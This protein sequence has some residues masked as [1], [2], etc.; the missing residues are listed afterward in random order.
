MYLCMQAEEEAR[1]KAA[2]ETEAKRKA[3]EEARR[4]AAAEKAAAE[5]EAKR[6]VLQPPFPFLPALGNIMCIVHFHI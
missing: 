2:V 1:R 5:A 3:E 6:K 4:K